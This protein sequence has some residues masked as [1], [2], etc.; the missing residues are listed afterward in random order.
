MQNR[1]EM[2]DKIT[3]LLAAWTPPEPQAGATARILAAVAAQPAVG[4]RLVGARRFR[5]LWLAGPAVAAA[6]VA[7]MVSQT[8]KDRLPTNDPVLQQ[9]ALATF[10]LKTPS[11]SIEEDL[12]Q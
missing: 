8:T 12:S 9:E 2:D 4:A 6:F 1:D 3:A 11:A 10:D 5:A 7:L